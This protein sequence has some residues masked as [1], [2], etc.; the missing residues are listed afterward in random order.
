M[1]KIHYSELFYSIQGEGRYTGVPS[2]FLRTFGCNFKCRNFGR[3]KDD[4]SDNKKSERLSEMIALQNKLSSKSKKNDIGQVFE[5]LIE[6]SSKRSDE[7]LSGRTS[8][9]KVVVFPAK[10]LKKGEYA[11]VLIE[12]CTSATLIGKTI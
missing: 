9:N 8:Q 6:G 10:N 5:V 1:S 2:V 3:D 11:N 12:K 7:Y 4:I